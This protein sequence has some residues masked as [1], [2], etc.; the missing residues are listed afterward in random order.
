VP[1][2]TLR[3]DRHLST[4]AEFAARKV[5]SGLDIGGNYQVAVPYLP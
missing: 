3:N 2:L 1:V 5:T 4:Y